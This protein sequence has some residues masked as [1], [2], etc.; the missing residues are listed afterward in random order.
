MNDIAKLEGAEFWN[1]NPCGG[2]WQNYRQFFEWYQRTEPYIYRVLDRHD[3]RGKAV[4][5]VGCGQGTMLNYLPG[6]GAKVYGID[7]SI[8]SLRQAK[9]GAIEFGHAGQ[10]AVALADA[11]H[12]PFPDASFERVISIGVLHHTPD[13]QA[14][15]DEVC[16]VLRPGGTAIV[17]L[18]R[19][20]NPKWWATATLRV[21][22]RFADRF[23][24]RSNSVSDRFRKER[25]VA[26]PQGTA[27]LELFGVPVLRAYTN[28]QCVRMFSHFSEVRISNHQPGFERLCDILTWLRPVRPLLGFIDRGTESYWGFYQVIEA[29][30]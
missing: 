22:A 21:L 10:I 14:G 15:I 12:L 25:K 26:S 19:R 20:G 7:M 16:R 13:T 28:A 4:L 18:Y 23:T 17:M 24:G 8:A 9:S 30:K 29:R 6:K 27:L 3:W 5:E 1:A 2:E 11:E